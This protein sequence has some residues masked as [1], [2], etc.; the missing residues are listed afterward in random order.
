[1]KLRKAF[2]VVSLLCAVFIAA[3]CPETNRPMTNVIDKSRVNRAIVE[4]YF[5]MAIQTAV[6]TQHTLY[7]Y[8]FI[9]NS[10]DLN[11]L[12]QRDLSILIE[13]LKQN[14]GRLI[15]HRGEID[16]MLY[17]SRTQ[18]VY[19]TLLQA[20]IARDHIDIRDDMPGGAG[21][22]STSVIEIQEAGKTKPGS[23]EGSSIG[24]ME[25]G[26]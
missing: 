21:M 26:Y 8:H 7:P 2:A 12:G 5:D 3:C 17:Q 4:N 22:P 24:D 16:E 9:K 15:V 13:Y 18:M 10:V 11:T 14:P 23:G 20:G 25:L 19:E 1:M 6:I